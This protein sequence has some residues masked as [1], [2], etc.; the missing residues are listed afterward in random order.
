[1][2]CCER[3]LSL[4]VLHTKFS[5]CVCG[6]SFV[7]A[8]LCQVY[9]VLTVFCMGNVM[10][11]FFKANDHFHIVQSTHMQTIHIN[12]YTETKIGRER[13][14]EV[15]KHAPVCLWLDKRSFA[16]TLTVFFAKAEIY[17][18]H[19]LAVCFHSQH[20]KQSRCFAIKSYGKTQ[21]HTHTC[22]PKNMYIIHKQPWFNSLI[23]IVN[24]FVPLFLWEIDF[25]L[26]CF[27]LGDISVLLF[28]IYVRFDAQFTICYRQDFP[29]FHSLIVP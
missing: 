9:L 13:E 14:R 20:N 6:L 21:T 11:S 5:D 16:W 28:V 1:M 2:Y 29:P 10:T 17:C 15:S 19:S 4:T 27:F 7:L 25:C 3:S 22:M 8:V 18:I 12:A 24:N 26:A 23:S